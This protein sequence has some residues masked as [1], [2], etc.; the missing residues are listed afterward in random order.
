MFVFERT[1]HRQLNLRVIFACWAGTFCLSTEGDAAPGSN[2]WITRLCHQHDWALA[3]CHVQVCA[4]GYL[5][6]WE[7]WRARSVLLMRTLWLPVLHTTAD[8]YRLSSVSAVWRLRSG[9]LQVIKT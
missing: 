5:N 9:S 3:S 2:E 6:A 1:N 7:H 8:L 4:C